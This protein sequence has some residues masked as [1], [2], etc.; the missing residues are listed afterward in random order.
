[1]VGIRSERVRVR[2]EELQKEDFDL[3]ECGRLVGSA[4]SIITKGQ[5]TEFYVNYMGCLP[6]IIDKRGSA[7][8]DQLD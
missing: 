2:R 4:D 6:S 8:N 5:L 1:M 7:A 3:L